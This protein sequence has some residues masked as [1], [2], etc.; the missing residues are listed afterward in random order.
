MGDFSDHLKPLYDGPAQ[1]TR[2]RQG[3]NIEVNELSTHLFSRDGFLDRQTHIRRVLEK[4]L[5][6]NKSKQMN[7]SRPVSII[8]SDSIEKD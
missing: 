3:S 1:L 8:D 4:D 5:L 7:L 2:E 6:F